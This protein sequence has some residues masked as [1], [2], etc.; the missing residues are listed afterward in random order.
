M[1]RLILIAATVIF[2]IAFTS[3]KEDKEDIYTVT[4]NSNGGSE[5]AAQTVEEGAIV[6]KPDDPTRSGYI[7]AAWY[8]EAALTNEWK[9]DTDVVTE[10]ITLH[11]KWTQN[12]FTVTFNSNGGNEV[13]AQAIAEDEKAVEPQPAPTREGYYFGGWFTDNPTLTNKWDFD[14]D[15]VTAD[16]TLYAKWGTVKLL[17]T[18]TVYSRDWEDDE[19]GRSNKYKFEYNEQNRVTKMSCYNYEDKLSYTNTYIYAGDDVVQY[20]TLE[21][22]KIGNTIIQKN[23]NSGNITNTI[24]L[25]SEGL[26]AGWE[27]QGRYH[28]VAT[29]YY[30]DG[31][32]TG[33]RYVQTFSDEEY[34]YDTESITYFYDNQK[35][36]L[37]HCKTPK[38][39][40]IFYLNDYGVKNNVTFR[41][42]TYSPQSSYTYEYDDDGFPAKRTGRHNYHMFDVDS[43]EEYTYITK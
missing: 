1:K 42:E 13:A 29:Y 19:F 26:P 40:M 30:Q 14:T 3:C 35:G 22:S 15:V 43:I 9:F 31:N 2:A 41:S 10:D 21:Y 8:R 36:A 33:Y 6:T 11:A 32:L 25:N 16:I 20:G 5:I 7:F 28:E 39:F 18:F 37:Y 38:W 24:E 4:F 23:V 17:E 34:D 27:K 12:T